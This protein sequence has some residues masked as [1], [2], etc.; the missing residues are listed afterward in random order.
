M[1]DAIPFVAV[2]A[3]LVP[4]FLVWGGGVVF[5]VVR[6][7]RHPMVS[8]LFIGAAVVELLVRTASALVPMTLVRSGRSVSELGWVF[9]GLNLVGLTGV[10]ISIVAVFIDRRRGDEAP[11]R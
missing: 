10:A 1:E 9:G 11:A 5:A 4:T 8:A 3:G 6:W 7:Q 2:L